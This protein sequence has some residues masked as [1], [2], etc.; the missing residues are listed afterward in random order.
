MKRTTPYHLI[1][2]VLASIILAREDAAADAGRAPAPINTSGVL[3]SCPGCMLD[4]FPALQSFIEH[5]E[6]EHYHDLA[7]SSRR[8]SKEPTLTIR[9]HGDDAEETIALSPDVHDDIHRLLRELGFQKRSEEEIAAVEAK[10]EEARRKTWLRATRVMDERKHSE[11][12]NQLRVSVKV[13]GKEVHTRKNVREGRNRTSMV[14]TERGREDEEEEI[15]HPDASAA[16]ADVVDDE[17]LHR[18]PLAE[19]DVMS[20]AGAIRDEL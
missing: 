10:H 11:R 1:F 15:I 18:R 4:E 12:P 7:L 13:N 3:E 19:V 16:T 14:T 2:V 9:G 20:G 17:S 5:E 6:Y 8:G